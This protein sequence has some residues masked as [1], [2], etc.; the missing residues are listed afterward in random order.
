MK[1]TG[2]HYCR[3]ALTVL[4]L[5]VPIP[6]RAEVI[7]HHTAMVE[8]NGPAHLCISCHD[9][10]SAKH[11]SFCTVKCE[12]SG[13][14]ALLKNYPPARKANAYAPAAVLQAKGL[15][16]ENGKVTCIS[17][18][19]LRKPSRYHLVLENTESRLCLVCHV[20]M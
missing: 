4:S 12:F 1:R 14:H 8:A 19:D 6:V 7:S 15:K 13:S 16:L 9:G 11:V 18:H 17:C 5:T 20:T 3:V 2:W 10:T